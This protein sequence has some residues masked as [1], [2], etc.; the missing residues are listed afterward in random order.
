[1]VWEVW[2]VR[3]AGVLREDTASVIIL[4]HLLCATN[5]HTFSFLVTLG[6]NKSRTRIAR[7]L[8]YNT[9]ES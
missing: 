9:L 3:R 6:Y 7:L 1:M 2:R 4:E 5:H 8:A